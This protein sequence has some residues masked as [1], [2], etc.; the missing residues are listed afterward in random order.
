MATGAT[1]R[2]SLMA[3]KAQGP[4]RVIVALPVGPP[5]LAAQLDGL[6]DTVICL[7]DLS[8]FGAVGGAYRSFPQVG[9]AAV[10]AA[11][12]LFAPRKTG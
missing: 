2:A 6:A 3:L 10:R 12:D 9:D 8:D 1:L 4:A 11:V 7:S 5:D